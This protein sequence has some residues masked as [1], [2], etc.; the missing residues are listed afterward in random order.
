MEK[1]IIRV[2][3]RSLEARTLFADMLMSLLLIQ[4]NAL[5]FFVCLFSLQ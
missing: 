1:D 2:Y 5:G 3:P 4:R